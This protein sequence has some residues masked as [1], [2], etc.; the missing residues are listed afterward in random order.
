MSIG[1][2]Y[3]P[4][5]LNFGYEIDDVL[6]SPN[7]DP[8]Q[9]QILYTKPASENNYA[10]GPWGGYRWDSARR[11]FREDLIEYYLF[12]EHSPEKAV[13]IANVIMPLLLDWRDLDSVA[14]A[15]PR[16]F[17]LCGLSYELAGDDQSAAKIY[18]QL[19]HDFPE[20]QYALMTKYK[21][22]TVTP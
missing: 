5:Q 1:E 3:S 20:S 13:E 7:S 18:W 4:T 16:Y 22:E 2:D 8:A 11:E 10:T 15:L 17:Y 6:F 14:W 9:V 12:I 19:W 21:L